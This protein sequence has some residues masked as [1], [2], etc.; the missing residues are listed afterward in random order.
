MK[1]IL[2]KLVLIASEV[3]H[4]AKDGKNDKQNYKYLSETQVKEQMR[5]LLHKHKVVFLISTKEK[6]FI[7][8]GK[9]S[10]GA[11]IWMTK[12]EV[13]YK[14]FDAESGEFVEGTY[15][16]QGSDM[17]DKG[18]FKAVTGAVKNILMQ[19]F[20]IPTGDDPE[21]DVKETKPKPTA[22]KTTPATSPE[23]QEW[24][25]KRYDYEINVEHEE[26]TMA[27]DTGSKRT[28]AQQKATIQSGV[29]AIKTVPN[30]K[31][32]GKSYMLGEKGYEWSW[33]N[34]DMLIDYLAT[35]Y[36]KTQVQVAEKVF[37][38]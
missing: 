24:E 14:F 37:N 27:H 11:P 2:N 25:P 16:S 10:T 21:K 18:G 5:P 15:D 6:E 32:G 38:S 1:N 29:F 33:I 34:N 20:L 22:A 7:Q 3:P 23:K 28:A 35:K 26:C 19:N 12:T 4:M 17:Q 36:A 30:H 13:S 31:T 9:T 8:T